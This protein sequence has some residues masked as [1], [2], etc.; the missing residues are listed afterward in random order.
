MNLRKSIKS[1]IAVCLV[2]AGALFLFRDNL[3]VYYHRTAIQTLQRRAFTPTF[4][5]RL[6]DRLFPGLTPNQTSEVGS[7]IWWE[8]RR[9]HEDALIRLGY[10]TREEFVITNKQFTAG[11][12]VRTAER[13]FAPQKIFLVTV[14]TNGQPL[15]ATAL[16]TNS[17][18]RISV[19]IVELNDWKTLIQ[20]LDSGS[21]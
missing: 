3:R 20:A 8:N 4:T 2:I 17:F 16:A 7:E 18:V 10:L 5:D 1:G 6:T 12:L 14:I 13:R 9:H 21:L 15:S 11:Q 19:P